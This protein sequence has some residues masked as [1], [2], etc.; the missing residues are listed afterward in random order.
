QRVHGTPVDG[1]AHR[2]QRLPEHLPA[3]DA[4]AADIAALAAKQV[5]LESLELEQTKQVGKH[6]M[7]G[8]LKPPRARYRALRPRRP[9]A[10]PSLGSIEPRDPA[11]RVPALASHVHDIG[12][13]LIDERCDRQLR[14]V[15]P[16]LLETDS[17]VFA[18]PLDGK[19]EI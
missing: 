9:R 13:E 16:R 18:H 4:I 12:I 5:L 8:V 3:E 17:Q 15:A 2:A 6:G 10:R 19:A 7:H 1:A 14:S 11:R